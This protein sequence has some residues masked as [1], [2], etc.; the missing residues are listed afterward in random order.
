MLSNSLLARLPKPDRPVK[1]VS[2]RQPHVLRR[3]AFF[4]QERPFARPRPGRV[5]K[6][7]FFTVSETTSRI[8]G[9]IPPKTKGEECNDVRP[10]T[11]SRRKRSNRVQYYG[12][13]GKFRPAIFLSMR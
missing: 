11:I 10:H 12:S 8:L 6:A 13:I 4:R 7:V 5:E 1:A 3:V 9:E 2:L